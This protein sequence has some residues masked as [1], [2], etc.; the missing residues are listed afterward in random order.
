MKRHTGLTIAVVVA[1]SAPFW[2]GFLGKAGEDA[3]HAV[4][5]YTT[6][7]GYASGLYDTASGYDP[8]GSYYDTSTPDFGS[9]YHSPKS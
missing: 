1:I 2:N 7:I 3:W 5:A 6:N 9:S 4:S 8:R